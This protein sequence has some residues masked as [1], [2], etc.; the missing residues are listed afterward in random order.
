MPGWRFVFFVSAAVSAGAGSLMLAF[1]VEPRLADPD[2]PPLS[3]AAALVEMRQVWK[4][5]TFKVILAQGAP[6]TMPGYAHSFLTMWFELFGFSH[7]VAAAIRMC[8]DVGRVLGSLFSGFVVDT[9]T[10][11]HPDHGKACVAQVCVGSSIVIASGIFFVLPTAG[12]SAVGWCCCLL[13]Y[14]GMISWCTA[15]NQTTFADVTPPRIRSTIYSLDRVIEGCIGA[16]SAPLVGVV[17][18]QVY[19]FDPAQGAR[20]NGAALGTSLGWN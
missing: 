9:A 16:A 13:F 5:R 1:G 4:I 6:G 15:V 3:L 11:R 17:A 12:A 2:A 20:D 19:G 14:G 10:E 7:F 18:V 8:F